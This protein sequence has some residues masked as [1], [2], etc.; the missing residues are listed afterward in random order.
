MWSVPL[1]YAILPLA[2]ICSAG[3][4]PPAYVQVTDTRIVLGNQFIE[5]GLDLGG[6]TVRTTYIENKLTGRRIPVDSLE[7]VI[8]VD[9]GGELSP[10]DFRLISMPSIVDV[11]G[12]GKQVV[13]HLSHEKLNL[14]VK[15]VYELF[16]DDFYTRKW[17]ETGLPPEPHVLNT[18]DLERLRINGASLFLAGPALGKNDQYQERLTVRLG[19][20]VFTD[21][22]FL[23]VEYPA[24]ENSIDQEGWITLRQYV[25]RKLEQ[26]TWV[27]RKAVIG[28]APN[29]PLNR[30]G[31]WFQKYID[32]IR[33]APVRRFIQW[34][35]WWTTKKPTEEKVL[36][37]ID[38]VKEEFLDKG[39]PLH[40]FLLDAHWQ[41][42]GWDVNREAFPNGLAPIKKRLS[43]VGLPMGL[44]MG[45]TQ[46]GGDR[47]WCE[48]QGYET[49]DAGLPC[50]AGPKWREHVRQQLL[51]YV[52][53]CD[54][55]C[56]KTD[57]TLYT[58]EKTDHGHLAGLYS[59]SAHADAMIDIQREIRR[60]RPDFYAYDGFWMSPWWLMYVDAIWPD[61]TDFLVEE[62]F[63]GTN[64]RD[65]Q[66]TSRDAYLY[67]RLKLD[68]FQVPMHSLMTCEPI[69]AATPEVFRKTDPSEAPLN[70]T[71][72]FQGTEDPLDRWTNDVVMH[73]CRGTGLTEL[74]VSPW[75][76]D[77][78]YGDNLRAVLKWGIEHNDILLPET[79]MILGDPRHLQVYGYAHFP[80]GTHRGIV[81]LRNPAFGSQL[82][83]VVLDES[84]GVAESPDEYV[85]EIVYPYRRTLDGTYRY[86]DTLQCQLDGYQT[87]VFEAT[88]VGSLSEPAVTGASCHLVERS[89]GS[90]VYEL[91]GVPGTDQ[92]CHIL[93]V[94]GNVT[95]LL[96]GKPFPLDKHG[97]FVVTYA[98]EKTQLVA[99]TTTSSGELVIQMPAEYA[100][101][102]LAILCQGRR[103]LEVTCLATTNGRPIPL[104]PV[105]P[106]RSTYHVQAAQG[107]QCFLGSLPVGESRI[108]CTLPPESGHI[109]MKATIA[110]EAPLVRHRLELS[111]PGEGEP[112]TKKTL[113]PL[114]YRDRQRQA[115]EVDL[116]QGQ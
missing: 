29:T 67:R 73:V 28:V 56:W 59:I 58:C 93:G 9:P 107:W 50:F 11:P 94:P 7:F 26:Q 57:Y 31:D 66:I 54:L 49:T 86:G 52:N 89:R 19:Q 32:R 102:S 90:A 106:N 111:L 8:R 14:Q 15:L 103:A 95:A 18:V 51:R 84:A 61:L 82:A 65:A 70:E 98:G 38:K 64:A 48:S 78:G 85:V 24:T 114:L 100:N 53:E 37:L 23:G 76:L 71:P 41:Q 105:R 39:I 20:P 69:R 62:V 72:P 45:F 92:S 55:N 87:L 96:D 40:A 3:E 10:R 109:D 80:Q 13:C 63:P 36:L 5:R 44:W 60:R 21:D 68:K 75:L 83:Q 4:L 6:N 12:G 113:L 110:T 17:L 22:F 25:G 91:L 43:E 81:G 108:R 30:V 116:Q 42:K 115:I 77:N 79:R 88:A 33:V 74:Y 2:A 104:T 99:E 101:G 1:T 112:S 97:R 34:Q 47:Q 27:S 46:G 16:G 35:S